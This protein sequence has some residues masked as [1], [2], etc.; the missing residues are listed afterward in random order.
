MKVKFLKKHTGH[1]PGDYA[2]IKDSVANYLLKLRVVTIETATDEEI[3]KSLTKKL[4]TAK[5]KK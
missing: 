4:K 1:N 2:E 3:E 5:K